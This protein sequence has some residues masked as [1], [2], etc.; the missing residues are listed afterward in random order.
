MRTYPTTGKASLA[1]AR[2]NRFDNRFDNQFARGSVRPA[3]RA[4]TTRR[5][6]VVVILFMMTLQL[7]LALAAF[8]ADS[9]VLFLPLLGIVVIKIATTHVRYSRD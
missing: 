1:L 7:C 5:D 6:G 2:L 3:A 4:D 8:L 9:F